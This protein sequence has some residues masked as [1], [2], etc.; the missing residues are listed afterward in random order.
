MKVTIV[1][2]V[3]YGDQ[4][5]KE[6]SAKTILEY[7][8]TQYEAYLNEEMKIK[9]SL[10]SYHDTRIHVCLYFI[11]PTGHSLKSLDIVCMKQMQKKVN[12]IPIISKSDGISKSELQTFKEQIMTELLN[13]DIEIYKFPTDDETISEVN[14]EMNN[15]IPF[16]VVGSRDEVV[17]GEEKYRARQYSWGTVLV[18]N[19]NH[20]DFVKLREMLV[21][22]NM[23]DLIEKTHE[24]HYE[25]HRRLK[26]EREG[27]N[28]GEDSIQD[29][30]Q[31]KREQYMLELQVKE[32]HI[33]QAFVQK[34]KD[35]ENELKKDEVA[36]QV[37][38]TTM[39][40]NQSD[41]K[42][43][44]EEMKKLLDE[45]MD[46]FNQFKQEFAIQ[47]ADLAKG[48]KPKK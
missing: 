23:Q 12:I 43:I 10:N 21:R 36:L 38:F 3:G 41:E 31:K 20:C 46:K 18:E 14:S 22:T 35:K 28:D 48:K 47:H 27:F 25:L 44:V 26:M 34:V 1:E 42:K 32:E 39:K 9:R 17:V 2:T 4:V 37:K 15:H 5:N 11:A 7:V 6:D 13:N 8:D 19:E 30:Y 33:R 24:K 45:D 29:G 16:A 40:Q